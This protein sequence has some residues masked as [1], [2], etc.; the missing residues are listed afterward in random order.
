[1]ITVDFYTHINE[2]A[3]ITIELYPNPVSE[4][5][6]VETS[7]PKKYHYQLMDEL[8][9]EVK[10]GFVYGGKNSILVEGLAKG[11][12]FIVIEDLNFTKKLIIE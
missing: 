8:S 12:Y 10:K 6:N 11:I 7:S 1:V 9:K 3:N 5:L 2:Q 4:V